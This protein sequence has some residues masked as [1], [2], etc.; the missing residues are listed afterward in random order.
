MSE[1]SNKRNRAGVAAVFWIVLALVLLIVFLVNQ[2]NIVRILKETEF[3]VHVFG[4]Q[5]AFIENYAL[6][7]GDDVGDDTL[8]LNE[9]SGFTETIPLSQPPQVAAVTPASPREEITI[10]PVEEP[11]VK[12]EEEAPASQPEPPVTQD[13]MSTQYLFFVF[14]NADGTVERKEV[15]REVSKSTTPLTA[16]LRALLEG[17]NAQD[18]NAGYMSFIPEGT[19]LLSVSIQDG[20]A[21]INLSEE[22]SF[23]QYGVDGYLA[24]L[25]QVVYTATAFN[26]IKNVRFFIEG[27]QSSYLGNDGVWIGSPLS[28]TDF[29]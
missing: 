19:K 13:I 27:E 22:F 16:S 24:Q 6:P 17:P 28:R 23:N 4:E 20:T 5:P 7:E 18:R 9:E 12:I 3:F 25:M 26:T 2:D 8:A 11:E 29:K 10:I 14:V 1:S 21:L 15:V